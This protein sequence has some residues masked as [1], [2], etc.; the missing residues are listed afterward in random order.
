[1]M[2][3]SEVEWSVS[4]LCEKRGGRRGRRYAGPGVIMRSGTFGVE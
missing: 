4:A 2:G 3:Y 1:M